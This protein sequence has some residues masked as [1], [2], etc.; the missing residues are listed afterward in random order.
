M[1]KYLIKNKDGSVSILTIVEKRVLAP[2]LNDE[3]GY[4]LDELGNRQFIDGGIQEVATVE[5]CISKWHQTLQE[6]VESFRKINDEEIPSDRYFRDAWVFDGESIATNIQKAIEIHTNALRK[7]RDAMLIAL[8]VE[9]LKALESNDAVA[10]K[11]IAL[12]KQALRDM[13]THKLLT[14]A[15]TTQNLKSITLEELTKTR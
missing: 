9:Y 1:A 8:D 12:K 14:S 4:R 10:A 11:N 5:E 15:N 7:E 2:I 13:P 3:G 6:K